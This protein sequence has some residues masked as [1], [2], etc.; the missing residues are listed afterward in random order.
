MSIDLPLRCRCGAVRGRA[1]D[2][3]PRTGNRVVCYCDDCQAFAVYLG[4]EDV[5]DER[6][7]T[8]IFQMTPAQLT[9]TSG[10]EL[11]Q[12]MRLSETGMYRWYTACCNTPVGNTMGAPRLPFVGLIHCFVDHAGDGR[13]RDEALGRPI[14]YGFGTFAFGGMPP[15]AHPRIPLRILVRS[16]GLLGRGFLLGKHK[17]SVFFDPATGRPRATP[18]VLTSAER[19]NLRTQVKALG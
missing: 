2:L 17:P 3:S 9:L 15:N 18:R 1:T 4:R 11:L 10:A 19:A 16:L 14:L 13:S 8:D 5:L 6:G 12:C 7:A